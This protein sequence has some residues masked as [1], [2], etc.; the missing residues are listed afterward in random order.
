MHN[1]TMHELRSLQRLRKKIEF[2]GLQQNNRSP[3][4]TFFCHQEEGNGAEWALEGVITRVLVG[5]SSP[6]APLS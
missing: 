1:K 3:T 5:V 6:L 4:F 2:L